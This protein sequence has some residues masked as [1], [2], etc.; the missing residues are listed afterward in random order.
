MLGLAAFS[1]GFAIDD[2]NAGCAIVSRA[3]EGEASKPRTF[4]VSLGDV[5]SAHP[6]FSGERW[7]P[8]RISTVNEGVARSLAIER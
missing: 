7:R 3:P 2:P 4:L 6:R 8:F 5:P 1:D